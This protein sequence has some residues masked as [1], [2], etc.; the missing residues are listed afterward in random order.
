MPGSINN[1]NTD[2]DLYYEMHF[3]SLG[4]ALGA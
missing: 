4:Q 2:G 3:K 1:Q